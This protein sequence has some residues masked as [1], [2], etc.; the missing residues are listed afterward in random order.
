MTDFEAE[1][2]DLER[3]RMDSQYRI[4]NAQRS[5]ERT[6]GI[7]RRNRDRDNDNISDDRPTKRRL[8]TSGE[9]GRIRVEKRGASDSE[10][11]TKV[12]SIVVAVPEEKKTPT[13]RPDRFSKSDKVAKTR[14]K[15]MFG[16]LLGH[17]RGAKADIKKEAEGGA[18]S[19]QKEAQQRA[20]QRVAERKKREAARAATEFKQDK[21]KELKL[22]GELTAKQTAKQLVFL[23]TMLGDQHRRYTKFILT[24]AEPRVY[25]HPKKHNKKTTLL[26][27]KTAEE[28]LELTKNGLVKD[29][30][31]EEKANKQK[32]D[33]L[34]AEISTLEAEVA[35]ET[36]QEET[37]EKTTEAN[38]S[39]STAAP[40]D[41]TE[42]TKESA[43]DT[44]E[45]AEAPA[46]D[47]MTDD[48]TEVAEAEAPLT[49]LSSP[50][51]SRSNSRS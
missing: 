11:D 9:G 17:L 2:F 22:Q 23:E 27:E 5:Y 39:K 26:M 13:K 47:K 6:A 16:M 42:D 30:E 36:K 46:D 49:V 19:K 7:S 35:D 25:F 43:P 10:D 44:V 32:A 50:S 37:T 8:V 12:S 18:L 38:E 4:R 40:E 21:I 41:S 34:A 1:L 31:E 48:A 14:S 45:A 51:R 20:S 3:E 29:K 28:A 33:E 24:T 15:R